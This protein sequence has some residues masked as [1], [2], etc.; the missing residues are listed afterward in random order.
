M[1]WVVFEVLRAI[2]ARS[3]MAVFGYLFVCLSPINN[4]CTFWSIEQLEERNMISIVSIRGDR[5]G[6]ETT[7]YLSSQLCGGGQTGRIWSWNLISFMSTRTSKC[8]PQTVLDSWETIS[9]FSLRINCRSSEFRF[10]AAKWTVRSLTITVTALCWAGWLLWDAF[11]RL[12][13]WQK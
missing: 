1:Y 13:F 7:E 3:K 2:K 4:I 10:L 11:G 8:S 12:I 9:L 5:T 6:G